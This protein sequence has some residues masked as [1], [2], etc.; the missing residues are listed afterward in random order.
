MNRYPFQLTGLI[1][2]AGVLSVATA[3]EPYREPWRPQFHFT[4]P[5]NWM[6]DPNGMVYYDGEYHLFYQYNPEG[7]KWGHMSWG[8]AVSKDLLHWE[9]LPV[10]L[11]EENDVMIFSGSV[12][13]D[14]KNTSGFGKGDKPPLV[15]LYT[16]NSIWRTARTEAAPG[17]SSPATRCWTSGRRTSGTRK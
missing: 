12:V 14:W 1:A 15:A 2:L 9:H 10:A 4:P 13:A 5:K 17:R 7:D 11:R 8:H 16:G 3:A 6:N